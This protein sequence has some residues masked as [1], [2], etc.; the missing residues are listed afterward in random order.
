MGLITT[1]INSV[2]SSLADQWK[3]YF[4]CPAID[5]DLLM[6]KGE[7][8]GKDSLFS[9]NNASDNVITNGSGIVVADGQCMILVDQGKVKEVCAQAGY[10]TYDA[11][12]EPSFFSG[13]LGEAFDAFLATVKERIAYGG[14]VAQDQRVY[15]INT[16]EITD[17][18]FGTASPII[19]RVV[20]NK[21]NLDVDVDL[22]CNGV[23]S[24]KIIN[25]VSFYENVAGNV[26]SQYKK[27]EID[28]Q[29]KTEFVSALQP[30]LAKLSAKGI[31]PSEIPAYV[32]ELCDSLNAELSEKWTKLRGIEVVSVAMN[33]ITLSEEDAQM[34]KDAQKVGMYTDASVANANLSAASAQALKDAANNEAGASVGFMNI[35]TALNSA[36]TMASINTVTTNTTSNTWTCECGQLND[37]NFCTHCGKAKPSEK[38]CS[39]CGKKVS[40]DANFCPHCGNKL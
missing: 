14:E 5:N 4:V 29:L 33:P 11:S 30:A 16:K 39:S 28:A 27:E 15:Y 19:F 40:E 20:D 22:R 7:H 38:Y 23:Y 17:N 24:Y 25:P 34:I 18:K 35:N 37:G 3:E 1:A 6:V 36:N 10:Y 31:R 2:N 26:S 13:S 12:S 9:G 8:K 21:V 32:S